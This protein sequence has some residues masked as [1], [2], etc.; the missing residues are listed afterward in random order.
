MDE[1][2]VSIYSSTQ[3]YEVELISGMLLENDIESIVINKQDS[4][5]LIGDIE[6]HVPINSILKAKKLISKYNKSE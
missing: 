4:A 2:W 3:L 1:E 5:Y 6:L